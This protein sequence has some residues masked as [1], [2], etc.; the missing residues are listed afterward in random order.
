ML[1]CEERLCC[2]DALCGTMCFAC[3]PPSVQAFNEMKAVIHMQV[4]H[5][6]LATILPL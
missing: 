1:N 4:K 3:T 6:S 5:V 2:I